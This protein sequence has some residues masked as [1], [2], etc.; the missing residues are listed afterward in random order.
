MLSEFCNLGYKCYGLER[1]NFSGQYDTR[2][3]MIKK[4]STIDTGLINKQIDIVILWHV[5][6]HLL[7]PNQVLREIYRILSDN[8]VLI[9]SVPNIRSY[10]ARIFRS[11][12]F[13][14]D[15][16]RHVYHYSM[17][18][19]LYLLKDSNFKIIQKHSFSFEHSVFGFI[20]STFNK[21]FPSS[22]NRYYSL[23]KEHSKS[24][25]D[26][27]K[28]LIWSI[29]ALFCFPFALLELILS[30]LTGNGAVI[31]VFAIKSHLS[32]DL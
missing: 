4:N 32:H 29:L 30:T 8:G 20:Q 9:I 1:E 28:I 11:H 17:K 31:T 18:S 27:L 7:E 13:H 25:S 16:P 14:L 26:Y 23:L 19:I 24:L 21:F 5:L 15:L 22:K 6:E 2:I 3:E 12:W 10:Q